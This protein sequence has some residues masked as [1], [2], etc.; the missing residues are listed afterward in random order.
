ME[1]ITIIIG[2]KSEVKKY[3]ISGVVI[4]KVKITIK[5]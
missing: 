4:I 3:F 1:I 5:N 2:V